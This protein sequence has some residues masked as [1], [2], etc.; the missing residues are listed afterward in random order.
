MN[1]IIQE[2]F[3]FSV[4]CVKSI[5]VIAEILSSNYI[6]YIYLL[7]MLYSG[8]E[9]VQIAN[10]LL[11][12]DSSCKTLYNLIRNGV[13]ANV[14]VSPM[15]I[16]LKLKD[17]NILFLNVICYVFL[18]VI[19]KINNNISYN[20]CEKD[21]KRYDQECVICLEIM[22]KTT[23]LCKMKCNHVFHTECINKYVNVSNKLS[24]PTCRR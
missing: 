15:I 20:V 19:I 17:C 10:L 2:T 13:L 14:I 1:K 4:I 7:L 11:N 5:S 6:A 9:L 22:E 21:L 16:T 24:C 3:V 12:E 8:I 23:D 18:Y